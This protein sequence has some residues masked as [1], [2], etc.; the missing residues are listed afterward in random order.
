MNSFS[1]SV[2]VFGTYPGWVEGNGAAS[3]SVELYEDLLCSDCKA[4]NPIW[5]E[6][7]NTE[8]LGSVVGDEITVAYTT[9]PLPYHVHSFQ[10][11]QI[12]PYLMDLCTADSSNCLMDAYKDYCYEQ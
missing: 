11:T 6:V 8:W 12:V 4:F 10:V 5:E 1:N 7:M 3:I 2:P 9:F